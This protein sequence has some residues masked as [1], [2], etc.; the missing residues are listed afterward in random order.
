MNRRKFLKRIGLAIIAPAFATLAGQQPNSVG[1]ADID[2]L[3]KILAPHVQKPMA[4]PTVGWKMWTVS[5]VLNDN[6]VII[7]DIAA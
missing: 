3:R 6:Y 5:R 7:L 2:A 1:K 4:G